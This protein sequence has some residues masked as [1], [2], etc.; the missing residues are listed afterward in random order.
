LFKKIEKVG[1]LEFSSERKTMSTIIKGL[2]LN[3][4]KGNQVLLKGAPERV[5]EKCTTYKNES[6]EI[7]AFDKIEKEQLLE[8]IKQLASKG[9]RC[10]AAAIIYDG[11]NLK[12]VTAVNHDSIL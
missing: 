1:V 9:L 12:D 10:L 8:N 7:K 2:N 3:N 11:G 4:Q 6:G 5:I